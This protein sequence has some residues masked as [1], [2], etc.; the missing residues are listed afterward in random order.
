MKTQIKIIILTTFTIL[1]FGC[2]KDDDN[3]TQPLKAE[4][5]ILSFV[6]NADENEALTENINAEID[7]SN[8]VITAIVPFN[9]D[10]SSLTPT[11]QISENATIT[12][13]GAQDFSS[14]VTYTITAEDNSKITYVITVN[15]EG[16]NEK[17]IINFTFSTDENEALTENI[18]A[19]IDQ[20]NNVITAIVPF[21]TDI[22]SLTPTIQISE[23]ATITPSGAQDFSSPVTYTVTAQDESETTYE[24]T[25]GIEGGSSEKQITSFVFNTD[26]NETLF[27]DITAIIDEDNKKITA[28]VTQNTNINALLPTIEISE[29]AHVSP[30]GI[31]DFSSPITYT[32]TAE[33]GSKINYE[34]TVNIEETSSEKQ[35]IN[36]VFNSIDNNVLN[37]DIIAEINNE[38]KTIV[39][40]IPSGTDITAL[41]PTVEIS[42]E[43]NI[44][45]TGVQNFSSPVTYTVTAQ[46]GTASTYE[47]RVY[48]QIDVL[49]DLYNAN[50]NNTLDWDLTDTNINN[51]TGV[52]TNVDEDITELEL[53][54]KN[55]DIIPSEIELLTSLNTLN[56][57][58]N[59]LADISDEISQLN[60]LTLLN[61]AENNLETINHTVWQLSN[62]T[63]LNAS[64]NNLSSISTEIG[65]ITN[66]TSLILENNNLTTLPNE[67]W[68]LEE[69]ETLY[70]SNNNL[71]T[72]PE[73]ISQL[74]N[75]TI[76]ELEG[77]GLTEISDGITQLYN[78][79]SLSLEK[80]E[81]TNI[82]LDIAGLFSLNHLNLSNNNI[83]SIFGFIFTF[84]SQLTILELGGNGLTN[85]PNEIEDLTN[86]TVLS[87]EDNELAS[88]PVEMGQLINLTTLSLENNN[89]TTIPQEVCDLNIANLTID[90]GVTCE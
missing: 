64:D 8:N 43:A 60:N 85:I 37:D 2:N 13:S 52:T 62:L 87:L 29:K 9:T 31:Q 24:V 41:T 7:Q 73:E 55:L 40:K 25:I 83:T 39:F 36:F 44:N 77:N 53:D 86:L 5:Q 12:P 4:K 78:L 57:N 59:N 46:D 63:Y 26:N 90:E 51:W 74:N 16:S 30:L 33:D 56:L 23:N 84:I 49:I 35:I 14:P 75:L 80:N 45:P 42:P 66:L 18:N 69:L 11:I 3:N 81:I 1:T 54:S 48:S 27:E 10:I 50:P 34:V 20:S 17:Q 21:N 82:P 71:G 79:T 61:L 89:L 6:F 76:L 88:I 67:I 22:S 32:V 72:I 47:V 28:I 65:L 58:N 38:T 15:I 70:L 19:E 68:E